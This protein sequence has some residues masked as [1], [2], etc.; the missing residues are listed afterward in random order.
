MIGAQ[1]LEILEHPQAEAHSAG[2]IYSLDDPTTSKAK[3]NE[4]VKQRNK[5]MAMNTAAD[6]T[7][8]S[9]TNILRELQGIAKDRRRST[10]GSYGLDIY[11]I[12]QKF[13]HIFLC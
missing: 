13:Y 9:H 6:E 12:F 5:H 2:V 7:L 3:R 11:L 1:T 8:K 10:G 4:K